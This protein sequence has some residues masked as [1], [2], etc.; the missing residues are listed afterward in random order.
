M[1]NR[2]QWWWII[3][4]IITISLFLKASFFKRNT[5]QS[6]R[7]V[8][9]FENGVISK[10]NAVTKIKALPEVKDYLKRVPNGQVLVN[11]EENNSYLIQVYEFKDG[12]TATFN[13]YKVDKETGDIE[14]EF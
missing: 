12:H 1:K 14:K 3:I 8:D 9:T 4:P 6:E 5:T 10:E 7:S 2:F 11:G 13:W